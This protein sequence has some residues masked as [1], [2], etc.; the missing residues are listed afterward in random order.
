V[1]LF[2]NPEIRAK[3]PG[4]PHVVKQIEDYRRILESERENVLQSYRA[5]AANLAAIARMRAG[6][7]EASD[8]IERVARNPDL[9][10][11]G[12]RPDV[13]LVVTGFDADQRDG[14]VW[15]KHCDV[16]MEQVPKERA[17]FLGNARDVRLSKARR[18]D[19]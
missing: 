7:P 11:L 1:K 19:P 16:L 2:G 15:K 5:V 8:L 13:G 4:R 14:K 18:A 17:R 9:L 12:T 6:A 3:A 10:T